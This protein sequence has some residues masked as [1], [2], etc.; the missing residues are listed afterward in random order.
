M[1]ARHG[2]TLSIVL[3]ATAAGCATTDPLGPL[4]PAAV[5]PAAVEPSALSYTVEPGDALVAIA[6]RFTG[7][8]A[9]WREI[10]AHNGIE[11]PQRL[12]IGRRIEIPAALLTAAQGGA[13]VA[14]RAS[15]PVTGSDA[16]A[17]LPDRD[18]SVVLSR[19]DA[20]RRFDLDPLQS[21]QGV[22]SRRRVRVIGTYYPVALY[23]EPRNG[24]PLARRVGPGTLFTLERQLDGWWQLDTDT[25]TV[26]LR[27]SDGELVSD[28]DASPP[29]T[30]DD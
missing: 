23:T 9:R 16:G 13:A 12:E 7:N 20:N 1:P 3:L 21:P 10:A 2:P 11:N 4:E 18:E 30:P 28:R 25:G 27:R 14:G 26:W 19:V 5:E 22:G 6:A 17:S 15:A 29:P 24:A 8:A